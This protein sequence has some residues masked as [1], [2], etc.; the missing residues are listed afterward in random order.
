MIFEMKMMCKKMRLDFKI[1]NHIGS[2]RYV[3]KDF[4]KE[5]EAA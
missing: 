4:S 1:E 3:I 5:G 2:F